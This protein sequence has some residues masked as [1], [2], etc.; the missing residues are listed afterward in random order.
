MRVEIWRMKL[1]GLNMIYKLTTSKWLSWSVCLYMYHITFWLQA[2]FRF[3][4]WLND[5]F[6]LHNGTNMSVEAVLPNI[7]F[8]VIFNCISVVLIRLLNLYS[9]SSE[10]SGSD[11]KKRWGRNCRDAC[12]PGPCMPSSHCVTD[13]C[14]SLLLVKN[15]RQRQQETAHV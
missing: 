11:L 4:K 14:Q 13:R 6:T 3:R 7:F 15:R 9:C 8:L 10:K 2:T 12:L 1:W 5:N